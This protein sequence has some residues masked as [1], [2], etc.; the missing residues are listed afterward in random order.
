MA[1]SAS[2]KRD[3]N[4][5]YEETESSSSPKASHASAT[6]CEDLCKINSKSKLVDI[7]SVQANIFSKFEKCNSKLVSINDLSTT[8]LPALVASF[9][10]HVIVLVATQRK[11]ANLFK[12]IRVIKTKLRE[13]YPAEYE[14]AENR[15]MVVM[16]DEED[17]I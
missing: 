15:H 17:D 1:S 3:L 6:F 16:S 4:A 9:K 8:Q 14:L 10:K 2:E 13:K 7:I 12:R 5:K 11:L